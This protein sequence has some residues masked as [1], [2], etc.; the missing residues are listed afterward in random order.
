MNRRSIFWPLTCLLA[1]M[2]NLP[3]LAQDAQGVSSADELAK[4][5]QNP[6]AS[7]I[8]VPF[9][10]NWDFGIGR[11]NGSRWTLN[12]QPVVP[13]SISE[14]WN[15]IGRVI[16][17]LISQTDVYGPSDNQTGLG[18]AVVSAFFSPKTPTAGGLIWGV[19]P[20]LLLPTATDNVLG[21]QKLGVGPTA[22][23]LKQVGAFTVG[24]LINHIWSVAGDADR[25]DVNLTFI[26]PFVA[27]NFKGGY[28]LGLSS[29]ISQ[30]W[31]FDATAGV[32]VLTG[33]KV[34]TLGSQMAQVAIGPRIFY[35]NGR[36]ADVGFR[37][38]FTL[39][40]PK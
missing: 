9:Q 19:G 5:L 18:D 31:D 27:R 17:P 10:N 14:D 8:S 35:G 34:V 38:I 37:A 21:T 30:N 29:E 2:L 32:L 11:A 36:A 28:A 26:Q 25:A 23:A 22:V 33:S 12:M 4:Q 1:L 40:F 39:L 20:V 6:V 7:L 3:L 16:L 15:L 13:M 24:G